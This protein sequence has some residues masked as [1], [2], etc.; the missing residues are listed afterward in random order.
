MSF[1]LAGTQVYTASNWQTGAQFLSIDYGTSFWRTG[2]WTRVTLP[3]PAQT[4]AGERRYRVVV[5]RPGA[6]VADWGIANLY[7]GSGCVLGCGGRGR[8]LTNGTCSCDSG[9]VFN[10]T[11]CVAS[12]GL[13]QEFRETF[14]AAVLTSNWLTISG[15]S[16]VGSPVLTAGQNMAFPS[17]TA[18]TSQSASRRMVTVDLDLR[19]ATFVE[20]YLM[21]AAMTTTYSSAASGYV[22]NNQVQ[23]TVSFSVDAGMTWRLLGFSGMPLTSLQRM[24]PF[25]YQLP[26]A[27]RVL[28]CRL[29]WWQPLYSTPMAD[30]WVSFL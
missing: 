24:M 22:N 27:A 4:G 7:M 15:G 10:G 8:C 28:G 14:D 9:A 19:N 11:T 13:A 29:Q 23:V 18:S 6:V 25:V 5:Q 26:A 17:S 20:F 21:T 12:E 16:V 30:G 1:I 2:S 3:L